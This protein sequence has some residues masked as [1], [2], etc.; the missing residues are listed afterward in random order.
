MKKINIIGYIIGLILFAIGFVGIL[1]DFSFLRG[2]WVVYTLD[3]QTV[4]FWLDPDF[5][6]H[7]IFALFIGIG[8]LLFNHITE[9]NELT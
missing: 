9:R 1:Y 2:G 6:L 3:T 4:R 5:W 7:I 8:L